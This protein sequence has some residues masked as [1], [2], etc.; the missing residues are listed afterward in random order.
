MKD[1]TQFIGC[2]AVVAGGIA[3]LAVFV[4]W[5]AEITITNL[6]AVSEVCSYLK[7]RKEF[8]KWKAGK[9]SK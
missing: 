5:C 9:S 3:L 2:V 4:W 1:F 6:N 7:H 8:R